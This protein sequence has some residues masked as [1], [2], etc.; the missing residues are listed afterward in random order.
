M[1]VKG[2]KRRIIALA[3]VLL[4]AIIL[5][6]CSIP[7]RKPEGGVWYCEELM[8]EIDFDAYR[9]TDTIYYCAKKYNLDGTYQDIQCQFWYGRNIVICSE[10]EQ[11]DYLRGLYYYKSGV[12]YITTHQDKVRYTFERIDMID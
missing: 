11:E 4:F 2:R 10:D 5:S 8:L 6:A 3:I 12:F 7:G 9:E 1:N